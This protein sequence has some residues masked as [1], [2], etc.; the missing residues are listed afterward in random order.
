MNYCRICGSKEDIKICK[1]CTYV[2]YCSIKCQRTDWTS[3]K[4]ECIILKSLKQVQENENLYYITF[5]LIMIWSVLYYTLSLYKWV[6][7]DKLQLKAKDFSILPS[8]CLRIN[9]LKLQLMM[10]ILNLRKKQ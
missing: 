1:G 9:Y 10:S 4:Q 8:T 3:H 5:E 7:L 6:Q 2:S